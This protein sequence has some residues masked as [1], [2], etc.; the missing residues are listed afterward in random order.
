MVSEPYDTRVQGGVRLTISVAV[1]FFFVFDIHH[2]DK[3]HFSFY[4]K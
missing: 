1:E 4:Y 3:I 2:V